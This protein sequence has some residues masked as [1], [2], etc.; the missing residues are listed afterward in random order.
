LEGANLDKA[1]YDER[2]INTVD[3]E[4]RRLFDR[5]YKIQPK[6]DLSE[7]DLSEQVLDSLDLQGAVLEKA[8]LQRAHLRGTKLQGAILKDADLTGA[9]FTG[10]N[11]TDTDLSGAKLKKVIGLTVKEL[12]T[13]KSLKG[14]Q[15]SPE[16]CQ[17]V[18]EEL[19]ETKDKIADCTQ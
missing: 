9:D 11:L 13:V 17:A 1:I 12:E 3:K 8:E 19:K 2:T 14:A 16:L 7:A 15:F 5:A 4:Y 18:R 10:A 6:S